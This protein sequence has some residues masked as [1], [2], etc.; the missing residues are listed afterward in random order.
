MCAIKIDAPWEINQQRWKWRRRR[1][2]LLTWNIS[3][4]V[5][6][7]ISPGE[8]AGVSGLYFKWLERLPMCA[9]VRSNVKRLHN[10]L[11]YIWKFPSI[12]SM[13][14]IWQLGCV[15]MSVSGISKGLLLLYSLRAACSQPTG[16]GDNVRQLANTISF[17]I[18]KSTLAID[19]P[20]VRLKL[21][22]HSTW[23]ILSK[24]KQCL[25][26]L[27]ISQYLPNPGLKERTAVE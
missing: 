17:S 16:Y 19:D 14:I 1:S 23:V 2:A 20:C 15:P 6:L 21:I 7:F 24:A 13:E 4:P 12:V 22:N 18:L 27:S 26:A 5:F 10:C 3:F 9:F 25:D 8:Q 11:V